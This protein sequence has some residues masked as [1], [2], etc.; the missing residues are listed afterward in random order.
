MMHHLFASLLAMTSVNWLD[1]REETA[2]RALQMM[3][4]RLNARLA[5]D[6]A[7]ESGL[8]YPDY[9]VLVALTDRA[10]GRM[11]AFELGQLLGWEQSRVSHHIAR[12]ARRGLVTRETCESDRRGAFITVTPHGRHAIEEAAPG[13]VATV[14]RAFLD[15]LTDEELDTIGR[16][17]TKIVT[18]LDADSRQA[19]P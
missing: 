2:W 13:H 16:A 19:R 1:E 9:V 4:M 15:H 6:L 14:R 5:R 7:A 3:Q 8:S 17:A 12:M 10:D 11:R 18:V